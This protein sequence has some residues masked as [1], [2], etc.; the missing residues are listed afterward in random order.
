MPGIA[1]ASV[2]AGGLPDP[3]SSPAL[4]AGRDAHIRPCGDARRPADPGRVA[5]RPTLGLAFSGG[6]F[7]ATLAALGVVRFLADAGVLAD[8]RFA[9]SVSGGSVAN[10]DS[11]D[12][13]MAG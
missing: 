10:L 11:R 7:R 2:Q 5:G 8:V 9:S 13:V 6:G 4:G 12:A 3:L 1:G